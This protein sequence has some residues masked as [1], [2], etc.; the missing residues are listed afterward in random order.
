MF[1][2]EIIL[3]DE[4]H[5]YSMSLENYAVFT[6]QDLNEDIVFRI[7]KF[8]NFIKRIPEDKRQAEW[9]RKLTIC[10]R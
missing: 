3:Y 5:Y 6:S 9:L 8:K 7:R 2:I 1:Q 10:L 4:G